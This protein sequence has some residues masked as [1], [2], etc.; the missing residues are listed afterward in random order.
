[1][2][3]TWPVD[4]IYKGNLIVIP[5]FFPIFPQPEGGWSEVYRVKDMAAFED[6]RLAVVGGAKLHSAVQ[7]IT[8]R[9]AAEPDYEKFLTM[10]KETK[11]KIWGGGG[12]LFMTALWKRRVHVTIWPDNIRLFGKTIPLPGPKV[13]VPTFV[14][15]GRYRIWFDP[16]PLVAM[17]E[18]LLVVAILAFVIGGV[19]LIATDREEVIGDIVSAPFR[20]A[21]QALILFIV[22][23]AV[24]SFAV[25]YAG[26]A[27]GG[28]A[29]KPPTAPAIPGLGPPA[30]TVGPP[31]ARIQTGIRG[32]ARARR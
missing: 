27:A 22:A 26:R 19:W 8:F 31:A 7:E 12:R 3:I 28:E 32:P 6:W 20:G 11:Q 13:Q 17:A 9:T 16:L 21:T 15:E 1:M 24:F 29:M 30:I 25:F 2:A 14:W 23:G 5:Q 10:W 18:L 4:T